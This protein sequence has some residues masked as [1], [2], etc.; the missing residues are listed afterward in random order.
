MHAILNPVGSHGDVHPLVGLGRELLARGHRVTLVTSEPFRELAAANGLAFAP[1]G[2]RDDFEETINHP[3]VWHPSKS[4][5]VLFEGERP[6]R[7]FRAG[8]G[9]IRDLV[10]DD[11]AGSVVVSGSLGLAGRL[12]HDALGVRFAT[13]HLQPCSLAS[14]AQPPV[15]PTLTV[16]KWWPHWLR[17]LMYYAAE[18][19]VMDPV[20]GP[21][22]NGLR[23]ELGLKPITRIF[24]A[25]R[26]SP[27][28]LLL[29]FPEWFAHAPD[30]PAVA[31]HTGFPHFD[32]GQGRAASPELKAFL[33]AGS[34]PVVVSFGT[35][36]RQARE[37]IAAAVAACAALG[38]RVLILA[39]SGAQIPTPLPPHAFHADYAPF[40]EIL[41][42]AAC[43]IHHGG[44]GT[45]AQALRAALPQLIR[46]MAFDQHD[47]AARL[48]KLGVAR[49]VPVRDFNT[50]R[51]ASTLAEL[52][53]SREVQ[54]AC[55]EA[56]L[57]ARGEPAGETAMADAVEALT[58]SELSRRDAE[59]AK[60]NR[61]H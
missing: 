35:A 3:D 30:W 27:E 61:N 37:P 34:P 38:R 2:S 40:G 1:A 10:G 33:D 5:R 11:V 56:A 26:H 4:L 51:V 59:S 60:E 39:K 41:P 13:V 54:A 49:S 44:I 12:A 52:L 6:A 57:R 14:V 16:P 22:V 8:Y 53:R 36:M 15:F 31:V 47:N 55:G 48:R 43:L 18:R 50:N 20:L 29:A 17:R 28:R 25:W 58:K 24:G 21:S 23:R 46:P 32:Q 19:H 9:A 7:M 42:H 45:S